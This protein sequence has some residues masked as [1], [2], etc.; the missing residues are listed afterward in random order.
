MGKLYQNL[1]QLPIGVRSVVTEYDSQYRSKR[2]EREGTTDSTFGNYTL[3][4]VNARV[5]DDEERTD[6][7]SERAATARERLVTKIARRLERRA[8]GGQKKAAAPAEMPD[9]SSDDPSPE[10]LAALERYLE[11]GGGGQPAERQ[12]PAPQ[13]L[14]EAERVVEQFADRIPSV[15]ARRR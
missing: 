2:D 13:F 3:A 14:E 11:G 6:A 4:L 12:P 9:M 7:L 8:G 10:E 5:N 1:A 15:K